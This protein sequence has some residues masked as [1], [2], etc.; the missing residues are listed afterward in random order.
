M[1]VTRKSAEIENTGDDD[2]F[3]GTFRVVL[4][5]PAE[6]RDGD[7]LKSEDWEQP[8]PEHITFDQDHQMSVAGTVGSG[9][10]SIDDDGRL[11]V[12]GTYSSLPRAQEV[13]TLVREGH[14]RTTSVAFMTKKVTKG[15]QQRTVRELLNGAFVAIPSNREAVV[16]EAKAADLGPAF[17]AKAVATEVV[18]QLAA[19]EERV[20]AVKTVD[21]SYEQ[22]QQA[23]NDALEAA[24]PDPPNNGYVYAWPLATFDDKVVYRVGG[25]T[26]LRGQWQAEYTV[27]DDGTV[28]LGEP[29]QVNMVEVVKPVDGEAAPKGYRLAV[30]PKNFDLDD[31]VA[32]DAPAPAEQTKSA[33]GPAAA[34]PQSAAAAE[35]V[36][37]QDSL[38][39]RLRSLLATASAFADD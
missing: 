9:S 32:V 23:I 16:L 10:P 29:E 22:R 3:P 33:A 36:A 19:D 5:T 13:R 12:D 26:D 17:D 6:D 35:P 7:E 25:D 20:V 27:N 1:N 30:T 24:Y 38:D 4:S 28:T 18:K 39:L 34:A 2:A 31:A 15:G 11:I 8:L 21:G 14:I 37:D